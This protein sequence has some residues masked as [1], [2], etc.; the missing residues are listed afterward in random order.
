MDVYFVRHGKTEWNAQGRMQGRQ[1]SP[2]LPEG[3][4]QAIAMGDH[5]RDIPLDVAYISPSGRTLATAGYIL[6][7]REDVE[8]K[9]D[10]RLLEIG[11][12]VMEGMNHVEARAVQPNVFL[13]PPMRE[14][15]EDGEHFTNVIERIQSLKE[16]LEQSD[17]AHVLV[18]THSFTLRTVH[19]VFF[20]NSDPVAIA[21]TPMCPP[22][23]LSHI[24]Y[25]DGQWSRI[26]WGQ[27]IK[28]D[29]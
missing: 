10:D 4:A 26:T 27:E 7:G 3:R 25:Q 28:N 29:Q 11:M 9:L 22:A 14:T 20:S 23:S 21:A 2:L 5:L 17:D 8:R 24:R 16:T 19:A 1:D 12:G 6:A 15:P 13:P 18:V